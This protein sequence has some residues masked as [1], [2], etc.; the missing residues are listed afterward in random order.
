M[1]KNSLRIIIISIIL[2]IGAYSSYLHFTD[3]HPAKWLYPFMI[4]T[5]SAALVAAI[6]GLVCGLWWLLQFDESEED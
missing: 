4:L 5:L 3:Q 1:K 6:A 2:A